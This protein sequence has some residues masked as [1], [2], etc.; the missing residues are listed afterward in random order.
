MAALRCG[1]R[2]GS[3]ELR[4]CLLLLVLQL[5]HSRTLGTLVRFAFWRV[6]PSPSP[7][8]P[9]G[10][11]GLRHYDPQTTYHQTPSTRNTM[12]QRP[13]DAWDKVLAEEDEEDKEE[14][15]VCATTI[16]PN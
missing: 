5:S 16:S 12:V 9:I 11:I 7:T 10:L 1:Y 8:S 3:A 15:Q 13:L 2:H 14:E 6:H 4:C